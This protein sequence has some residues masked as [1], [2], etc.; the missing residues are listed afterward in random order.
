MFLTIRL[1]SLQDVFY[2]YRKETEAT[3]KAQYEATIEHAYGV[4][5]SGQKKYIAARARDTRGKQ[6]AFAEERE[7][8][9]EQVTH[10]KATTSANAHAAAAAN[11][12]TLSKKL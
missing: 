6:A 3:A 1:H 8:G 5:W 10:I 4:S 12:Y 2:E 7:R 11:A 9:W